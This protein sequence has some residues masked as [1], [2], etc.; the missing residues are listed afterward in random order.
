M[1]LAAKLFITAVLGTGVLFTATVGAGVAFVR[2]AGFI[3]V[4]V[5]EA[6]GQ[7][8]HVAAPAVLANL[9]LAAVPTDVIAA[10]LAAVELPPE[11]PRPDEVLSVVGQMTEQLASSEDFVLVEVKDNGSHVL[12][13][14]RDRQLIIS[15]EGERGERFRLSVPVGTVRRLG[16]TLDAV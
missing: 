3:D 8:V 12:I 1:T 2:G 4:V 5:E 9:A 11:A 16:R 15:V 6:D 10:E 7:R 14:K 13:E